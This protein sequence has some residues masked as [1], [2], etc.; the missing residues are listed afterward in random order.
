MECKHS[1]E[2]RISVTGFSMQEKPAVIPA[3]FEEMH[4]ATN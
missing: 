1:I 3:G 4:F 2:R